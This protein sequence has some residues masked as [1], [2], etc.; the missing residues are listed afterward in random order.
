MTGEH[1]TVKCLIDGVWFS[2]DVVFPD[3]D[4]A[5]EYGRET[6]ECGAAAQYRITVTGAP[7]KLP[8]EEQGDE[9]SSLDGS[10]SSNRNRI[11]WA[12]FFDLVVLCPASFRSVADGDFDQVLAAYVGGSPSEY[13]EYS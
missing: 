3:R 11:D 9:P 10:F 4:Q 13:M 12:E 7:V 2:N 6:V 8:Q 5:R 1:F